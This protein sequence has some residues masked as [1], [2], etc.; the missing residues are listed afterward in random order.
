MAELK[1]Y[2]KDLESGRVFQYGEDRHDSLQV[3]NGSLEYRN[4]QNGDGSPTGYC[5]CNE[6]GSTNWLGEGEEYDEKYVHI[7]IVPESGWISVKDRLPE[8]GEK[9][10]IYTK[11]D[12]TTFGLYTKN[13]GFDKR[14]GFECGDGF[15]WMNT[16]SH[17]MPLPKPPEEVQ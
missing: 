14:E 8:E 16:S 6:D 11:T 9:V 3:W 10:L 2:I 12:I 13:H 7:G 4:L 15:M 17:W 1:L 5:F